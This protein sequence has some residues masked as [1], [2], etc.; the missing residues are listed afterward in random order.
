M[1]HGAVVA[2]VLDKCTTE[3]LCWCPCGRVLRTCTTSDTVRL[4]FIAASL[5]IEKGNACATVQEVIAAVAVLAVKVLMATSY[6]RAFYAEC[7]KGF[8]FALLTHKEGVPAHVQ[9]LNALRT[10][11]EAAVAAYWLQSGCNQH[12][13]GSEVH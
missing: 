6:I 10:W 13:A 2:A 12:T 3:Q 9:G 7:R 8:C 11:R 1:H 5:F 4:A